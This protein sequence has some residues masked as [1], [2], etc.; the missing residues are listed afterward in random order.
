MGK[1]YSFYRWTSIFGNRSFHFF[2]M[3]TTSGFFKILLRLPDLGAN[4]KKQ[5][6]IFWI[7]P[8]VQLAVISYFL[9]SVVLCVSMPIAKSG[10]VKGNF[11]GEYFESEGLYR[12]LNRHS[13]SG[14]ANLSDGSFVNGQIYSSDRNSSALFLPLSLMINPI[15]LFLSGST[16]HSIPGWLGPLEVEIHVFDLLGAI[17]AW[18]YFRFQNLGNAQSRIDCQIIL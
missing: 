13:F 2:N 5:V 10:K 17:Y 7:S 11:H 14:W 15:Q 6:F 1:C 8:E 3:G 9:R 18:C 16:R 12:K 4:L